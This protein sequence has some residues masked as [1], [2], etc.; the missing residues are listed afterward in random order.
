MFHNQQQVEGETVR[1]ARY[2]MPAISEITSPSIH[3][4][5]ITPQYAPSNLQMQP[6]KQAWIVENPNVNQNKNP[7]RSE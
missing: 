7:D 6:Y 2:T 5:Q 3:G 4:S 1:G